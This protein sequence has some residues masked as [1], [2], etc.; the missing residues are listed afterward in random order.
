M[1]SPDWAINLLE[2]SETVADFLRRNALSSSTSISNLGD[3]IRKGYSESGIPLPPGKM[4]HSTEHCV[5]SNF[6]EGC[7]IGG[8]MS[9][10]VSVLPALLKGNVRRAVENVVTS[11]NARVAVFFGSLMSACNTG[12]YFASAADTE[13]SHK[14]LRGRARSRT[15]RLIVG[16]LSGLSVAVLPKGV[17]RFIVFFLLTRSL[18]VGARLLKTKA[19]R[20]GRTE[21]LLIE[22]SD[23]FS[24]HEVV[25]L[26]S[27]SMTVIITAWFRYTH[28]VP[29]G[30]LQ[31]LHG[32][33]NLTPVQVDNVQRVLR[34]DVTNRPEL[35]QAVSREVRLCSVIHSED[36]PCLRFYLGFLAKGI[37]TRSGPFYLKLYSLPLLFSIFKRRGA[38]SKE[39]ILNHFLKRVLWSSLFLATMNATAAGTVCALD[40]VTVAAAF[41]R[42]VPLSVHVGLGGSACALS[43]YLEQESRRLEL[44]LYLFGQAIQILV[45]AYTH[46]GFCSPRGSDVVFCA[47][48]ISMLMYAFWE[49]EALEPLDGTGEPPVIIR[50]GYVSLISK[51]IDTPQA[52]HNFKI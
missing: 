24:A 10:M 4:Y 27:A 52:R 37:V 12:T 36:E 33:N 32:I 13:E 7:F 22:R 8:G 50:P 6:V 40:K 23:V 39:L 45:N 14:A 44:A 31:F 11:G 35:Q 1:A 38:V 5:V 34:K 30:Y 21:S 42:H 46:N 19:L 2:R 47:A 41:L 26:A 48:S 25:G 49:Q 51:I 29:K 9:V 18:E 16:F 17:R 43:L 20:R 3:I 28:H 15:I